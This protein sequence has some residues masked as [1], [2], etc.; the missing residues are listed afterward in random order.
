MTTAQQVTVTDALQ[1]HRYEA[2]IGDEVAG[3][4]VYIRTPQMI[5]FVHTEVGEDFGGRGVGSALARHA[6]DEARAQ[7]LR[8]LPF[9]PFIKG[10]MD[11][12]PEY[13]DLEHQPTSQVS[14]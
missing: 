1:E 10:W 12:H 14:D 4:A 6:L 9:C 2:R 7:G 11:K 3:V 13:Q 5:A 8:V